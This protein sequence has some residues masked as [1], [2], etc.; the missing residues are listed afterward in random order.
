MPL[1]PQELALDAQAAV[2]A[3][4]GAL[5]VHP[6]GAGGAETM[7]AAACAEAL[8]AIR[9][10]CPGITVGVST[11][12]WMAPQAPARAGLVESWTVLPDFA[13]VNF[14]E[15]GAAD[16]CAAL[17]RRGIGIEAGIWSVDDVRTLVGT[18]LAAWCLRVLV[19]SQP[20]EPARA[21]ADA[22]AIDEALDA[23]EIWLPR[24]HHGEGRATWTVLDAALA[25]GRD[26]RVGFEDTLWLPDGR[27]AGSNAE[28][29]AEAVDMVRRHGHRPAVRTSR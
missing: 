10:A 25:L 11:G 22:A 26:I 19:E 1:T 7:D 21:V 28:L 20:S 24:L 14:S 23:A 15:P 3:G 18:G 2:S 6:R 12:A 17:I 4:A 9:A 13:S 8:T 27:P 16:V 29:V 5:H